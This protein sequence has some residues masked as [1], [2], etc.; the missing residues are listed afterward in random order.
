MASPGDGTV[1]VLAAA[2]VTTAMDAASRL[3]AVRGDVPAAV[4]GALAGMTPVSG[5]RSELARLAGAGP[6]SLLAAL[7]DDLPTVRLISGYARLIE[8]PPLVTGG[9]TQ[10][11][12]PNICRGWATGGSAS[13]LAASGQSVI[14]G[15]PP[16][17]AFDELLAE[18]A[19]I[20]GEQPS[21]RARCAAAGSWTFPGG[22]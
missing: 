8:T 22:P 20:M 7:L 15:T 3:T 17:P 21:G 19:G 18:A 6:H 2:S 4:A 9:R 16:A 5:F 11:P 13:R 10:A 1:S 12:V 14:T